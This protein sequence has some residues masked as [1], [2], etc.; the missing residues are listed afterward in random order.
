MKTTA[1]YQY[2]DVITK[3]FLETVGRQIQT[4]DEVFTKEPIGRVDVALCV[5]IDFVG[6][7]GANPF[8][9]Q[10]SGL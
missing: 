5:G 3:P 7:N 10:K 2:N 1:M 8:H 4:L 9:Y 6:I